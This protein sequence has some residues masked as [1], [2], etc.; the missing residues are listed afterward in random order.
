MHAT[1]AYDKKCNKKNK[2]ENAKRIKNV[3]K[4]KIK[5]KNNKSLLF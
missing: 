3:E 1:N 5:N 4:I 2:N